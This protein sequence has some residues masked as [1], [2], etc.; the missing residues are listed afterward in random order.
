MHS[1]ATGALI[2]TN[3]CAFD[4]SRSYVHLPG[5]M[6]EEEMQQHIDPVRTPSSHTTS[7]PLPTSGMRPMCRA[8]SPSKAAQCWARTCA[9]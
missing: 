5:V 4:H 2:V 6:T 1:T 9:T 8:Q 3:H 7:T